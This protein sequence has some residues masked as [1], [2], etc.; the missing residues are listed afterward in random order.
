VKPVI[1]V[2]AEFVEELLSGVTRGERTAPGDTL[3]GVT[4][5]GKFFLWANLKE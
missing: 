2:V 3:Q 5:E 1:S 4:S